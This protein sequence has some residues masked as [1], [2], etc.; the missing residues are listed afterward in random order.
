MFFHRNKTQKDEKSI[1]HP[2]QGSALYMTNAALRAST[3]LNQYKGETFK[4]QR[5]SIG[6]KIKWCKSG[7]KK[8]QRSAK[9]SLCDRP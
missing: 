8:K 2:S 1:Q 4:L 9:K 6:L 5:I 3:E 7:E